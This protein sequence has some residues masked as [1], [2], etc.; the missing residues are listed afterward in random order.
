MSAQYIYYVYA[1][2]RKDGTP[3]YI[4]KGKY[5]RAY[6]LHKGRKNGFVPRESSRIVFIEKNLSEV[7]ALAIE[8]RMIRWYGRKDLGTGILRNLTDGGDGIS[9]YKF[10][11]DSRQNMS[12]SR[13]GPNNPNFGRKHKDSFIQKLKSRVGEE[14]PFYGKHHT[15]EHKDFLS[16]NNPMSKEETKQIHKK[17]VQSE[18]YKEKLRFAKKNAPILSCPYCGKEAKDFIIKR[19]HLEKCKHKNN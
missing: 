11:Q 2:L 1:Y 13:S 12:E 4:G 10:S 17:I 7:G 3:Y 14:N 16:K 19:D 18:E 8:R 6:G 15:E 9:G 5:D